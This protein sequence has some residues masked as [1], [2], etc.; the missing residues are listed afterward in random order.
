MK[1]N[2]TPTLKVSDLIE[3]LI[4]CRESFGEVDVFMFDTEDNRFDGVGSVTGFAA[5]LND[6]KAIAIFRSSEYL[7]ILDSNEAPNN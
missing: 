1:T 7:N 4:S 5:A 2:R 3:K 6:D